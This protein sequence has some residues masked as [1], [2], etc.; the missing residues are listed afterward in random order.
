MIASRKLN[1]VL[2]A[3]VLILGSFVSGTFHLKPCRWERSSQR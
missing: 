3:A 1:S 2:V